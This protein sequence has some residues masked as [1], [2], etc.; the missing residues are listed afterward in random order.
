MQNENP[1]QDDSIK[2]EAETPDT[3]KTNTE[4]T[5]TEKT[6]TEKTD[7]KKANTEKADTRKTNAEKKDTEKI[8]RATASVRNMFA[9]GGTEIPEEEIESC[10]NELMNVYRVS[11]NE[12]CRCAIGIFSKKYG[13]E[14]LP[15]SFRD[16]KGVM[17]VG[18]IISEMT[19]NETDSDP[20]KTGGAARGFFVTADV[21]VLRVRDNPHETIS[22][23]GLVGDETGTVALIV[24]KDADVM[25][26]EEGN[27]YTLKNVSTGFRNGKVRLYVNRNSSIFEC[28]REIAADQSADDET[29][30]EI[31]RVSDL[32]GDGIWTD[33]RVKVFRLWENAHESI[34]QAGLVGDETGLVRMTVWKTSGCPAMSEGKCYLIRNA[35]TN[36]M[37]GRISLSLNRLSVVEEL[38][39][40]IEINFAKTSFSGCGVDVRSGS[41]LIRRCPECRKM[42]QKS[43]CPD[44]GKVTGISD[45]R[46]KGVIDD[47]KVTQEVIIGKELTE[48]ILGMTLDE[49]LALAAETLEPEIIAEKIRK[50]FIGRYFRVTGGKTE[51]YII[52]EEIREELP[53]TDRT[54]LKAMIAEDMENPERKKKISGNGTDMGYGTDAAG[55]GTDMTGYGMPEHGMPEQGPYREEEPQDAFFSPSDDG[56]GVI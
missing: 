2:L 53:E 46:I 12:A 30:N 48:Q 49:A 24:W 26:L 4:K 52:V 6:N 15:Y 11:E 33:I 41:G 55:Y 47:G 18:G 21:R 13:Q 51:R 29:M 8:K 19:K 40:D 56:A 42:L 9:A 32:T 14:R 23:S 1:N 16:N 50:L 5:N 28:D 34:S 44:H 38:D 25:P 3:E 43:S 31:R 27:C 45:L 7:R 54:S 35:V 39:D 10:L 17:T 20:G 37:N 22:M 36:E